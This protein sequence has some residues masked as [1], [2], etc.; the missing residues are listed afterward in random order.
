MDSK[1]FLI[2]SKS[3]TNQ[4]TDLFDFV[5]PTAAAMWNLRWQVD[6][7]VRAHSNV[8]DAEL[9]GRFVA[10]SN[11]TGANLKRAC[12]TTS[13]ITQQETFAKF[14]LID[15]CA[16][17]ESWADGALQELQIAKPDGKALQFPNKNRGL[18]G[19]VQKLVQSQS[20]MMNSCIYP[21]LVTHRK[22]SLQFIHEL[23]ICYRYFKECRNCI[24]HNAGQPSS[25]AISAYKAYSSLTTSSL[26]LSEV[27]AHD[28]IAPGQ[29]VRL[30]LRGIVAFSEVILRLVA[31]FDAELARSTYAEQLFIQRWKTLHKPKRLL[32]A[33]HS[34]R[35]D[36][37]K[38]LVVGLGLPSP[39]TVPDL[40]TFLVRN[41]LVQ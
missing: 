16:L 25:V 12:I 32:S 28:A 10:G 4:I 6:G 31:T 13:W 41:M 2:A 33:R 39:K 8:S 36:T 19:Y 37:I 5:W 17:Y 24:V 22:N 23:L 7:Y 29:R 27:P 15:L 34:Q 35:H 21:S 20:D 40:D 1:L 38:R 9:N 3:V 14:L 18:P 30:I 26:G 11:I